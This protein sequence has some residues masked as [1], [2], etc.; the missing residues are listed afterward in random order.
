MVFW[1]PT[2]IMGPA[3]KLTMPSDAVLGERDVSVGLWT[4]HLSCTQHGSGD[5]QAHGIARQHSCP[6][7]SCG[8]GHLGGVRSSPRATRARP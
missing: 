2:G 5:R 4:T 6:G 1:R 7:A 8:S 3:E